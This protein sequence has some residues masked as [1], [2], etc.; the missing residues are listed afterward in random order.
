M[1]KRSIQQEGLMF[2][3]IYAPA[4][5]HL[6]CKTNMNTFK[7]RNRQQYNNNKGLGTYLHQ[8]II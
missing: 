1:I 6:I 2:I 3:N 7:G 8:W 5:E 4:Q